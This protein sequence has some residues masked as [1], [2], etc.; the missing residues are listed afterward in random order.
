MTAL[1]LPAVTLQLTFHYSNLLL[2]CAAQICDTMKSHNFKQRNCIRFQNIIL[3]CY[4]LGCQCHSVRG[5]VDPSHSSLVPRVLTYTLFQ[6]AEQTSRQSFIQYIQLIK[7]HTMHTPAYNTCTA[8]SKP[9]T[10]N[11]SKIEIVVWHT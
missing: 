8:K 6:S 9:S 3:L 2:R 7:R 5:S 10:T 1:L 4:Y 11:Q